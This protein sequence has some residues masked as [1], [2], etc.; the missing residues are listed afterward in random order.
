MRAEKKNA[1]PPPYVA[2]KGISFLPQRDT[3]KSVF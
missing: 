2:E 1:W 3:K